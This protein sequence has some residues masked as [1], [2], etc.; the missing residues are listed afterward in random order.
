MTEYVVYWLIAT[1]LIAF[2][3]MVIDKDRAVKGNRRISE[4]SLLGWAFLGGAFGTFSASRIV[5]HKTRKQPFITQMVIILIFEIVLLAL[6]A[7]GFLE[8]LIAATLAYLPRPA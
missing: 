3:L 6:W 4:S 2:I 1:N 5:R 7:T 8:P